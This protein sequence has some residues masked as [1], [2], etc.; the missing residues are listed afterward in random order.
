MLGLNGSTGSLDLTAPA[1]AIVTLPPIFM[2]FRGLKA[3]SDPVAK[4]VPTHPATKRTTAPV[5]PRRTEMSD[6][7]SKIGAS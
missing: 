1:A 3:Q 7:R 2:T 6:V 5:I 4:L